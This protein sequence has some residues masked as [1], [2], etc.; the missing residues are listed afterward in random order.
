VHFFGYFLCASKE[1]N[2]LARRASGS[3]ALK[4]QKTKKQELDSSLRWNDERKQSRWIP[5]FAGMTS[6]KKAKSLGDQPF[7]C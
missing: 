3:S 5:A 4:H 1:S 2:P 6:K 7:G